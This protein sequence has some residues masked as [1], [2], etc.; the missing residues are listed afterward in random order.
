VYRGE[1]I[2]CFRERLA[3]L[4][5]E[6]HDLPQKLEH[7]YRPGAVVAFALRSLAHACLGLPLAAL[8]A[9]LWFLP[10][11]FVGWLPRRFATPDTIATARILAAFVFFPLWLALVATL[12]ALAASWVWA[13]VLVL[14]AGPLGLAALAF[15]DWRLTTLGEVRT[16]LLLASRSQ[17][18]ELLLAERAELARALED[19]RTR[20]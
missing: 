20:P 6:A 17:L 4:G 19:L 9:C 18:R 11:R 14:A 16:F 2:A 7:P 8:G 3:R 13:G 1:R 5:L 10:H 12:T 15:R